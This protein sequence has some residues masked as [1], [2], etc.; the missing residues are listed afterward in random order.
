VWTA[1][2]EALLAG[3]AAGD[4]E[5]ATAFVRRFQAR[6]FGL[7]HALAGDAATAEEI[8]QEA[9]LRV[10]RHAGAYDPRRGGV[11]N[12]VLTITRNLAID[13]LRLRRADPIDPARVAAL[14]SVAL[15]SLAGRDEHEPG[16]VAE[17]REAL[18]SLPAEQRRALLLASLWGLT[19]AEIGELDGVPL[20]TVKSRVRSAMLK[21]SAAREAA[22]EL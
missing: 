8:A 3:L 12:W 15:G 1:S 9:F 22:D 18:A 14:E 21:L 2:D 5:A 4:R 11:V 6:V 7:A 10:W 20:G 17:I 16:A 13:R 19:A